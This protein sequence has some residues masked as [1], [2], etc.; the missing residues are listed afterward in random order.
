MSTQPVLQT[1]GAEQKSSSGT[2]ST[3]ACAGTRD[4]PQVAL[5]AVP[6]LK[7]ATVF[8]WP[9]AK[10]RVGIYS[11]IHKKS[12][13]NQGIGLCVGKRLKHSINRFQ[14]SPSKRRDTRVSSKYK[15]YKHKSYS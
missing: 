2:H 6:L 1:M 15:T 13:V 9:V 12:G 5:D 4:V 11:N 7:D 14:D 3:R 8:T 10:Y